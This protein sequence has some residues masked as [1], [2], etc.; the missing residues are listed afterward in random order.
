MMTAYILVLCFST[1]L[2]VYGL[3][4]LAQRLTRRWGAAPLLLAAPGIVLPLLGFLTVVA[5]APAMLVAA[6]L[7]LFSELFFARRHYRGPTPLRTGALLLAALLAVSTQSFPPGLLPAP[8][9]QALALAALAG[10]LWLAKY[11]P[12]PLE[13]ASGGFLLVLLPLL[14]T[15]LVFGAPAFVALD[16][17][18]VASS[19]LAA[20]MAASGNMAVAALRAPLALITGWLMLAAA[21]HGAWAGALL[22]LLIYGALVVYGHRNE[23][24]NTERY[25]L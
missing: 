13:P 4:Q 17:A 23:A 15:P 8:A 5:A 6:T 11:I 3:T 2:V 20:L 25:A 1:W 10:M 18:L 9:W 14:L 16:S 19:L 22:S 7:V 21:T 12:T 24:K